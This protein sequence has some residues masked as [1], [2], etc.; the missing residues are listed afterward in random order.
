MVA[1]TCRLT[2]KLFMKRDTLIRNNLSVVSDMYVVQSGKAAVFGR[3]SVILLTLGFREV[4][5]VIGDDICTL[6]CGDKETRRR[7]YTASSQ[8]FTGLRTNGRRVQRSARD[9]H[10]RRVRRWD[11]EVW[12]L[13]T[14]TKSIYRPCR[15]QDSRA[16]RTTCTGAGPTRFRT[17]TAPQ[18]NLN[19]QDEDDVEDE[20]VIPL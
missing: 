5:D 4:N 7:H 13:L 11:E 8:C 3:H 16:R 10:V 6:V 14:Y 12:L 17:S 1:L 2:T 15:E 20:A 9:G 18:I 19:M